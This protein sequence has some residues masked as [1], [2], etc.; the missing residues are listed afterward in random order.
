MFSR[1]A[2]PILVSALLTLTACQP[3]TPPDEA[4]ARLDQLIDRYL[5]DYWHFHP[6]AAT[7]AGLGPEHGHHGRLPALTSEAI[8]AEIAS[9]E[10]TL[11]A[12]EQIHIETLSGADHR[13]DHDLLG[14]HARVR[15]AGLQMLPAWQREPRRYLPFAAFNDLLAFS[16]GATDQQRAEWLLSRLNSLPDLLAQG[17]R[18]LSAPPPRFVEDAI[19]GIEA[20]RP[21]FTT[22]LPDFAATV[23]SHHAAL[24]GAAEQAVEAIDGYLH[25]LREDLSQRAS[26][27]VAVGADHY[28]FLLREIH[29]L[30]MDAEEMIALGRRYV[31]ETEALLTAHAEQMS[32]GSTWQALTEQI[33][34]HHPQ[35]DD[36]LAAYCRDIQ[37]SRTFII[38]QDLVSVPP[39]EE[40][41]CVDSD[42]SQR[43]FS[44]FGTF[45]T[46]AP[47]SDNKIGYLILHPIP[48][49]FDDEQAQQRL[50][51]HD[52][53][54]IEVIAP[55]E[56][57]P[58]HH[59]Q[60][61]LAQSHSRPLRKV[62][63]T[64]V[65]T[66]G[67]GLYTEQLMHET[68]FFRDADASRLTQLRLQL[69]RAWRVVLDASIHSGEMTVEDARQALAEGTGMAYDA[70]AGEV[71]IYVYRPSYAVGYMVGYHEMMALRAEQQAALGEAFDLKA[72]HD[73]VLRLGSIPFPLVRE[74][75]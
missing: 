52:F 27:E 55:H 6:D 54:W 64:P 13:V 42:P 34:D 33:R 37:R 60:A 58:G 72:F 22:V 39:N 7:R 74:L 28:A 24:L 67:W 50:R 11:E 56:A 19:R 62:Y 71:N 32:P 12:L 2:I 30:E 53:S 63:S 8:E 1:L 75:L 51:S 43:A 47:F 68:G 49:A 38:E 40:V 14:R 18:H 46:P 44:P 5:E 4:G 48:E 36:L 3:S 25:F 65:F 57:Y 10:R 45:R 26:G 16:E 23:P 17:Q 15:L 70:T 21:W 31:A 29:G 66:E 35:R 41:R 59:L 9:L 69:W 73:R 61:I 20:Q